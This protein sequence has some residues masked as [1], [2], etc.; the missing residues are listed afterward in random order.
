[1]HRN[2]KKK[3]FWF[4]I[5]T[6]VHI[7]IKKNTL[8]LYN[9]LTGKALEYSTKEDRGIINLVRRL[10]SG[11]N[12]QVTR[13][14]GK[15]LQD[16]HI[17]KFVTDIRNN[18]M[19]D[20]IDTSYS[21]G[22][23][24]QMMPILTIQGNVKQLKKDTTRS[25]GENMMKYL[26]EIFLFINND[27]YQDCRMCNTAYKQFPCCAKMKNSKGELDIYKIEKL[28]NELMGSS[29]TNI[30]ILGGDIFAYSKFEELLEII[31]QHPAQKVYYCHYKNLAKE[32]SR[33]KLFHCDSSMLKILFSFPI[34]EERLQ[35]SL[36]ILNNSNFKAKLIFVIEKESEFEEAEAIISKY[37]IANYGYLPH[38]NGENQLFFKE[39]VFQDQEEILESRPQLRDIHQNMVVNNLNFGRLTITNNGHIYSN[40]NA[41]RLGVLGQDSLYDIVFKELDVGKSW[42][43]IR[44]NLKPCNQ[45]TFEALCPP[46][47]NYSYAFGR[48]NLCH[49]PL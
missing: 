15:D 37:R 24:V 28:F 26:T 2:Q 47:S 40:I 12:L 43:R 35:A 17:S 4:Y 21:I 27:C 20:I 42:K 48:N 39:N 13:L 30:N 22:K 44:K 33:Y 14:T 5:D 10:L 45:C 46:V 3:N 25:V 16:P 18:F 8:L 9:T 7:S 34:E 1:L 29:L 19:G 38:F 32:K 6:Y 36:Q 11:K 31:N 49:K 41:S 23:P